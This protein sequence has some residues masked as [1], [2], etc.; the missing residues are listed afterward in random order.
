MTKSKVALA[1]LAVLLAGAL[2]YSRLERAG[3]P[4]ISYQVNPRLQEIR[5]YWQDH[6]KRFGSLG[7]LKAWL[8][9]HGQTLVFACNGG[10]FHPDYS[11]VGLFIQEG[12]TITPL[13]TGTGA[14]NFYRQP[15]GVFYITADRRAGICTTADFT[16]VASPR[17]ATQSGPMLV[18]RNGIPSIFQPQSTNLTIRNGVGI[19][20][21]GTVVFA[22]SRDKINFYNFAKHFQRLG[23]EQAL[24]FD[25]FV[26]RTYLPARN[27]VQTDGD[28]GV[29]IGV[30]AVR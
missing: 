25:G 11:P 23:C 6:G 16:Q 20:P 14:G 2:A 15:N 10:M 3:N 18:V 29:I 27:W 24:Y 7:N 1:G 17:F 8:R 19:L 12:R 9:G 13:N 4:I 22:M 26:S 21:D 28:F 5:L 30:T